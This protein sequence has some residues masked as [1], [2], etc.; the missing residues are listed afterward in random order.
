MRRDVRGILDDVVEI[1]G[2]T[3]PN[4]KVGELSGGQKQ[5]VAIARA[6]HFRRE[7]LLLDEP[8]SALSVRVAESVL[9]Y[10]RSL[11]AE[12]IASVLVSHNLH[13]AFDV[14]DRFIVMSK[15]VVSF[16]ATRA[17]LTLEELTA[18]VMA[19]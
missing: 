7:L 15:G 5:A 12:R 10:I 8:T 11:K 13:H 17:E 6:V 16:E 14:C 3:S 1:A 4:Q 18:Q 2:I 19:A 9:T